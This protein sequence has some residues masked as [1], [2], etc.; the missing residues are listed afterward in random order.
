MSRWWARTINRKPADADVSKGETNKC[1][2]KE[3]P[4]EDFANPIPDEEQSCFSSKQPT[5]AAS[6]SSSVPRSNTS[7]LGTSG[8]VAAHTLSKQKLEVRLPK[9]TLV[10]PRGR[11][12]GW[13]PP[14]PRAKERVA[15]ASLLEHLES[16]ADLDN[17]DFIEFELDKFSVYV[18]STLY[19][20]ELRRS[21][22]CRSKALTSSTSMAS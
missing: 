10:T 6:R 15:L 4:L 18:E 17:E 11:Y 9:S 3:D 7:S 20:C 14:A 13:N 1:V 16:Q 5:P 12:D 22:S 2:G 19:P 21:S 8:P